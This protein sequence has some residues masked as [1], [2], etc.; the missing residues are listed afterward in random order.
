M[1]GSL[2][3]MAGERISELEDMIIDT[4]KTEKQRGKR[5]E[6]LTDYPRTGGQLQRNNIC[7]MKIP[8]E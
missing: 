4:F 7:A 2:A 8:E 1:K 6:N 3:D 5:L